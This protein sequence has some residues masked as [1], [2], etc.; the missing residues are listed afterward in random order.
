ME[1]QVKEYPKWVQRARHIGPV[2]CQ[3]KAEEDKLLADWRAE[4]EAAA[5]AA[6]E[7]AEGD[8]AAAKEQAQLTL[9]PANPPVGGD[10]NAGKRR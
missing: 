10:V 5:L 9:K 8:A 3:D 7:A 1:Q 2:L 6:A 4:Q